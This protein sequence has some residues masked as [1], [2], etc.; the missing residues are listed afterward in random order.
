MEP[1]RP[2]KLHC[3]M[4]GVVNS[5]E[6]LRDANS[7]AN[8]VKDTGT[9]KGRGVFAGRAYLKDQVIEISP[10][11][12]I[13]AE[14][15]ALPKPIFERI[16]DWKSIG[17]IPTS[18]LALGHGSLFNHADSANMQFNLDYRK[19]QISYIAARDIKAGEELTINYNSENGEPEW[20]DN[21][22]FDRTGI[23]PV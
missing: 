10:V 3:P 12:V 11:I 20:P 4:C 5:V 1:Y 8:I 22:W 2:S 17:K 18:A 13:E 21:N 14:Y 23:K 6:Y 9:V 7:T 16:Y 15:E 19:K